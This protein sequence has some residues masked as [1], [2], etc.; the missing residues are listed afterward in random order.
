MTT[1]EELG[2]HITVYRDGT[3][4]V[5]DDFPSTCDRLMDILNL[6]GYTREQAYTITHNFAVFNAYTT[7]FVSEGP[8]DF[9]TNIDVLN[10]LIDKDIANKGGLLTNTKDLRDF[11]EKTRVAMAFET[12]KDR[13][14]YIKMK[15]LQALEDAKKETPQQ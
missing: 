2:R 8:Y 12:P 15:V 9:G 3:F 6:D 5:D 1:I 10:L 7:K 14:K 4:T 13:M 11:V